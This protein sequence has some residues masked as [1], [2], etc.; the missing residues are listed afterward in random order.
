[1]V[2]FNLVHDLLILF[3]LVM[4]HTNPIIVLVYSNKTGRQHSL[5]CIRITRTPI[6]EKLNHYTLRIKY[7]ACKGGS[8]LSVGGMEGVS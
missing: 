6:S 4:L 2:I 8:R 1:M 7:A 3:N 5:N